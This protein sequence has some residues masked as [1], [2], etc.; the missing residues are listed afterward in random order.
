MSEIILIQGSLSQ[1]SHTAIVVKKTAELLEGMGVSHEVMDLRELDMDF[2]D[3]RPIHDYSQDMQV[4][5][6]KLLNAKAIIFGMPVYCYSI[7]GPLKNFIDI[8]SK[9]W[10]G[11]VA[12]IICNSGGPNSYLAS[13]ELIKIL[14]FETKT[15]TVQPTVYSTATDFMGDAIESETVLLKINEMVESL[16]A[17][18]H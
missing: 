4:A 2:C 15:L 18:V 8:H 7:S 14:S 6:E 10:E 1:R 3:A 5:H 16:L 17:M 13:A 11:K 12:G 9:A